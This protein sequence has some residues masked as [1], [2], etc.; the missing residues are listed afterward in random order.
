[1]GKRTQKVSRMIASFFRR[2]MAIGLCLVILLTSATLRADESSK[3]IAFGEA[4][5]LAPVGRSARVAF[6]V[7]PVAARMASGTWQ[8]PKAGDALSRADGRSRTW[9]KLSPAKDGSYQNRALNGGYAFFSVV[10]PNDRV[11]VLEASGH[12][13]VWVNGEPRAGDPYSYGYVH[14]PVELK[15]GPNQF[16]FTVA[17]GAL[18]A[19]LTVPP[20][21]LFFNAADITV[22]DL[23]AS[24]QYDGWAAV[25]V[26]N[27]TPT[28][29]TDLT[30]TTTL[31]GGQ[32]QRTSL[33][34]LPPLSVSKAPFRIVGTR[35]AT[36][37]AVSVQ[38]E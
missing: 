31:P 15:Q 24:R 26:I 20:A 27:A 36:N 6:P 25:P 2:S 9:E 1:M 18:T 22:P 10:S 28:W 29:Q 37:D 30:V 8:P 3:E 23:I 21:S 34:A 5:V 19:K 7:D 17:R 33:P 32:P 38:L 13:M 11:M 16:L 14:V 35:I 12:G 4:L